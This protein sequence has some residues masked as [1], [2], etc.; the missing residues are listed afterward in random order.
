MDNFSMHDTIEDVWTTSFR[1]GARLVKLVILLSMIKVFLYPMLP[2][3]SKN[4]A[5]DFG[6]L[7][8]GTLMS[9]TELLFTIGTS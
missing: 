1:N 4:E 8:Y 9:I 6:N 7:K 2:S 5:I 3:Y